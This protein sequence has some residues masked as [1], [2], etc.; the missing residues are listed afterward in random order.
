MTECCS[1]CLEET[2]AIKTQRGS[3]VIPRNSGLSLLSCSHVYHRSCIKKWYMSSCDEIPGC[4]CC[5]RPIHFHKTS[6]FYID[7]LEQIKPSIISDTTFEF[8]KQCVSDLIEGYYIY[9]D[10]ASQVI[11]ISDIMINDLHHTSWSVSSKR[12]KTIG[13]D[14][15][16]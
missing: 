15:P 8:I 3:T 6:T 7:L 13:S 5:R 16:I 4:P 14:T 11:H 1:I 2:V 9:Y 12:M 10:N